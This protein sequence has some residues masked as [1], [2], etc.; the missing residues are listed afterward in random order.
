[1]THRTG[2]FRAMTPWLT[3]RDSEKWTLH[4]CGHTASIPLLPGERA[5]C[6]LKAEMQRSNPGASSLGSSPG[7]AHAHELSAPSPAPNSAS[8][9][10][11]DTPAQ[12]QLL[13]QPGQPRA[14]AR[15]EDLLHDCCSLP[16]W[17]CRVAPTFPGPEIKSLICKEKKINPS[18][19]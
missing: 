9:E 5:K 19:A 6:P 7:A 14:T 13:T 4:P 18:I 15:M 10:L 3:K 17:S 1:M 2:S 12:P 8:L 11:R 16:A